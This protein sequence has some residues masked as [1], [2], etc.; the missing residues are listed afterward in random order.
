MGSY[1][2]YLSE[3]GG[4][5]LDD[6]DLG[7]FGVDTA[8]RTVWIVLDYEGTFQLITETHTA[9][10]MILG[11]THDAGSQ[12]NTIF[13]QSQ[14]GVTRQVIVGTAPDS[15]DLLGTTGLGAGETMTFEDQS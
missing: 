15:I 11:I 14:L 6:A 2:A 9:Q 7:S 5:I 3:L 12:M 4:D 13:Y 1:A 8:S 10:L